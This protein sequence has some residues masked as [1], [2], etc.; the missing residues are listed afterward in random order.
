MAQTCSVV[1][2]GLKMRSHFDFKQ[3]KLN[4][5]FP[6]HMFKGMLQMQGKLHGV[7]GVIEVHDAR[8]PF[9]GRNPNLGAIGIV[10]PSILV[11]NKRDLIEQ[12][13]ADAIKKRYD[14]QGLHVVFTNSKQSGDHGV[15]SIIP[16]LVDI[17]ERSNRFNRSDGNEINLMVL[18]IPNVGKSSLLN[19]LRC[20]NLHRKKAAPVGSTPGVTKCV[21]EKIKVRSFIPTFLI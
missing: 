21:M 18:G 11:L 13:K 1:R 19:A 12:E 17:V 14:Y 10:K 7:D 16:T 5:W 3:F 15:N 4:S 20:S 2:H 8:I 6:R 9:C